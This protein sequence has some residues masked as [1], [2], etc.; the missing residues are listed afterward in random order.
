MKPTVVRS[1]A[2]VAVLIAA[3]SN[4][5]SQ[6]VGTGMEASASEMVEHAGADA[7]S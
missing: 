1:I 5:L 3:Y 2:M 6:L 7:S 4:Q